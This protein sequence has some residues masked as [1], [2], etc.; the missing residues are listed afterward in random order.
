[1]IFFFGRSASVFHTLTAHDIRLV[2]KKSINDIEL[3]DIVLRDQKGTIMGTKT[4]E[5]LTAYE[6]DTERLGKV[7]IGPFF[8]V[9]IFRMR[10][11]FGFHTVELR[12]YI[13]IRVMVSLS[14][15]TCIGLNGVH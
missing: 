10:Y 4:F 8:Y 3:D 9:N 7:H 13:P 2:N 15:H 11:L 1:L 12:T 6:V 5:K 14:I